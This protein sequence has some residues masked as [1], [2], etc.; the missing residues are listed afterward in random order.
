MKIVTILAREF[1]NG[2]RREPK[3]VP[4][5]FFLTLKT[6]K[7]NV[8]IG[9]SQ[10]EPPLKV[11]Q[12]IVFSIEQTLFFKTYSFAQTRPPFWGVGDPIFE[13]DLIMFF[14][15]CLNSFFHICC[16]CRV[17]SVNCSNSG[18]SGLSCAPKIVCFVGSKNSQN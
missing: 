1:Q 12:Q 3:R 10:H 9:S 8:Q 11:I 6:L 5:M 4:T 17:R 16:E 2:A 14:V 18:A 7:H 15:F 13:H